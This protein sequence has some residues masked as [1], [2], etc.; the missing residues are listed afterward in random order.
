MI[1]LHVDLQR[2]NIIWLIHPDVVAQQLDRE[3]AETPARAVL[4]RITLSECRL[5]IDDDT[6]TYH[7]L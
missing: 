3:Q 6:G 2:E 4:G 5:V 7:E 1:E